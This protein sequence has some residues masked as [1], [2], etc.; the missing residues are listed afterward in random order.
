MLQKQAI[1]ITAYSSTIQ[2][3]LPAPIM[4][5]GNE[6]TTPMY[7]MMGEYFTERNTN[8]PYTIANITQCAASCMNLAGIT[9]KVRI[10]I[11]TSRKLYGSLRYSHLNLK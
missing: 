11:P 8:R 10:T 5:V 4:H 7:L 2:E 3:E 1:G 6:G 9:A